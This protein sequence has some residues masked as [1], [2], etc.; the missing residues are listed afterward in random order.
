MAPDRMRVRLHTCRI[1]FVEVLVDLPERLEIVVGDPPSMGRCPL[2]EFKT[3]KVHESR[4]VKVRRSARSPE[5][6]A[7]LA[8]PPAFGAPAA[9]SATP[10]RIRR[11]KT[12]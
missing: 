6:H 9:G 10:R 11:S 8:P 1:R 7:D 12:R 3:S 4:R 5:D 2:C